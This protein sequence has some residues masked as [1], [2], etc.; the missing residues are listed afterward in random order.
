MRTI[1]HTVG[2]AAIFLSATT[3]CADWTS[4]VERYDRGRTVGVAFVEAKGRSLSVRCERD[5]EPELIFRS[6]VEW[7][8]ERSRE[9]AR[10]LIRRNGSLIGSAQAKLESYRPRRAQSVTI[11]ATAR[12]DDLLPLIVRLGDSGAGI[13]VTLQLGDKGL[14][15]VTFADEGN[16]KALRHVWA[17]CGSAKGNYRKPHL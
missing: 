5:Q 2:F 13:S 3:A 17:Y 8:N 4:R 12:G 10:L 11:R 14:E 6:R 9:T 1:R 7:R 15:T 16:D